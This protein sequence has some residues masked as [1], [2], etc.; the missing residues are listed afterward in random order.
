MQNLLFLSA[1]IFQNAYFSSIISRFLARI[2]LFH[3]A[4][5]EKRAGLLFTSKK[6]QDAFLR[7]KK[8][9]EAFMTSIEARLEF[10]GRMAGF[11]PKI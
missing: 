2:V 4:D 7:S 10:Q 5:A 9:Q 8:G 11:A 1:G 6:G 3:S